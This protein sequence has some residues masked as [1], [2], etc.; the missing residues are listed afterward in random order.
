M[1]GR[2]IDPEEFSETRLNPFTGQWVWNFSAPK[3]RYNVPPTEPLC[4]VRSK[5]GARH[6]DAMRWG[7]IPVWAKDKKVGFSSINARADG[8]ETKPAFRGA[9]QKGRR[10]LIITGGFYEWQVIGRKEKQP[11]LITMGN[12]GIMAMAGLWESWKDPSKPDAEWLRTCTIITTEPNDLVGRIHDRMPVILGFEDWA[13]WLGE[14]PTNNN[15]LRALLKPFPSERLTMWPVDRKVGNV[16]NEGPEL[17]ER[18]A[19]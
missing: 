10:C 3:R 18:I 14:E 5:D 16:K 6:V 19:A 15:E 7:L 17:I 13:K 2:V 1:C 9:W 8:V 4:V 12:Q 11:H